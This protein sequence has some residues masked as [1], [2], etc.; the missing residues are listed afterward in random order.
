MALVAKAKIRK[1]EVARKDLDGQMAILL[2]DCPDEAEQFCFD[3]ATHV[4]VQRTRSSVDR[5]PSEEEF[6]LVTACEPQ[7]MLVVALKLRCK[8]QLRAVEDHIQPLLAVLA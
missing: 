6:D 5:D 4:V 3:M 8:G 2:S 1:G 7:D